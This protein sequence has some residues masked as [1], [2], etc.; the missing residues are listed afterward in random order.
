MFWPLGY[1]DAQYTLADVPYDSV[2]AYFQ[3]MNKSEDA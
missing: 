2:F 3:A 1:T